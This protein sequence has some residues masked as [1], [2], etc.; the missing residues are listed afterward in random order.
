VAG[1]ALVKVPSRARRGE[2]VS[3]TALAA[4]PMETG[5]RTDAAGRTVPRN[6]VE[7]FSCRYDGVEVFAA[8][9]FPAVTA[10]PFLSFTTVATESG[11]L[12]FT[13]TDDRGETIR[14]SASIVVE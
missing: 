6:I 4:H 5:Y 12:E 1:R 13:W 10:N 11:E 8:E 3:I 14:A 2:V 9:L 7:R